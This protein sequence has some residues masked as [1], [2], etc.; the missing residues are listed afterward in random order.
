MA[1]KFKHNQ[2]VKKQVHENL[3][4]EDFDW[5][6]TAITYENGSATAEVQVLISEKKSTAENSRNFTIAAPA[7]LSEESINAELLKLDAF[8][9]STPI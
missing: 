6:Y 5:G 7:D 2:K 3:Q 8:S 1:K 4:A 9:G